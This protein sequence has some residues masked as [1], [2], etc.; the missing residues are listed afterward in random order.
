[1]LPVIKVHLLW[2]VSV[3]EAGTL[4][5]NVLICCCL[6][7]ALAGRAVKNVGVYTCVCIFTFIYSTE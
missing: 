2:P 4:M 5:N 1:M 3:Q 7:A 6:A